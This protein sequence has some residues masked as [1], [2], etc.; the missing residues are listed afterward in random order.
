MSPSPATPSVSEANTRGTIVIRSIRRK[1]WPTGPA[2]L[3][4]THCTLSA[5]HSAG[6]PVHATQCA[7]V[8]NAFA[9]IPAL[10]PDTSPMMIL[11]WS[12]TADRGRGGAPGCGARSEEHTSELQSRFDLVCRLLL[13]KKKN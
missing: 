8:A 1:I 13:E 5:A 9:T 11:V 12:F 6:M 7:P 10:A 4:P 3:L 2:M